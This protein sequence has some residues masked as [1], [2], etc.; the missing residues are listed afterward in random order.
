MENNRTDLLIFLNE[1]AAIHR[2]INTYESLCYDMYQNTLTL[3]SDM[4]GV[5]YNVKVPDYKS[6]PTEV[7]LAYQQFFVEAN[8]KSIEFIFLHGMFFHPGKNEGLI[9]FGKNYYVMDNHPYAIKDVKVANWCKEN[10]YPVKKEIFY[11]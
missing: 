11:K 1:I 7:K 5:S 6:R 4:R 9:V 2:N 8:N 3:W 10:I